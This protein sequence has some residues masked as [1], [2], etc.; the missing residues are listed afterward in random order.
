MR[1]SVMLTLMAFSPL[2]ALE[3]KDIQR[4]EDWE[5]HLARAGQ[6]TR[7]QKFDEAHVLYQ[8]LTAAAN[9]FGFPLVLKAKCV[10][11]HGSMLHLSGRYPEAERKFQESSR[12]W[13]AAVGYESDENA[14]TL[15]NLG[16]AY[17]QMGRFDE[18]EATYK[19]SLAIR[20][21][22]T[23][24]MQLRLAAAL[25]NLAT[26][27]VQALGLAGTLSNIGEVQR[28]QRRLQEADA[29]FQRALTIK[30]EILGA[31]HPDV[32][33]S[34]NN[35]AALRQDLGDSGGAEK[36]YLEALAIR[37]RQS[38]ADRPAL[39][40][41]LNNLG[42]LYRK[43]ERLE[44]AEKYMYRAVQLWEEAL[45]PQ[46]PAL[47]AG[48]N[49]LAELMMTANRGTDAEP[50]FRRALAIQEASLGADHPQ[51]ATTMD[52]LG[53]LFLRQEKAAG[54]DALFR[55]ALAARA[56][57]LGKTAK[58]T[59]E[60]M[61]H[62]GQALHLQGRFTES[63]R[64]LTDELGALEVAKMQRTPQHGLALTEL[65]FVELMRRRFEAGEKY[66]NEVSSFAAELPASQREQVSEL[67][68]AYARLLRDEKRSRDAE[69][70]EGKAKA[71]LPQ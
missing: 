5:V 46:H 10:N 52:N 59:L 41:L 57:R 30:R 56:A 39:A 70:F 44:N 14:T 34:L 16:E 45:G 3:I 47:A 2:P 20:E 63:E 51:T 25:N 6:I 55:R 29:T 43:M 71:F 36:L 61:H 4:T 53:V 35:L 58:T 38:P 31:N 27:Q 13:T 48:L 22:I 64:V 62:L 24:S 12:L 15:N 21:A 18:A 37:E 60:T 11:N 1:C 67:Y 28:T 7:E 50:L 68:H 49:N 23:K 54:A 17:R 65:A 32:A 40:S 26:S 8:T 9:E 42:T 69:R 33:T 66:L 19:S